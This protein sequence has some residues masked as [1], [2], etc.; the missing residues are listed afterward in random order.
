[1]RP[2]DQGLATKFL[3]LSLESRW[4]IRQEAMKSAVGLR[5]GEEGTDRVV[6]EIRGMDRDDML[7][8]QLAQTLDLL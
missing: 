5:A 1:M 7:M 4:F 6:D 3:G 8:R 2:S